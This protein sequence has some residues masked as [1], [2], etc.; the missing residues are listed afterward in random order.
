[1]NQ[2]IYN[3]TGTV[4]NQPIHFPWYAYTIIIVLIYFA[5]KDIIRT[6]RGIKK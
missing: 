6:A 4:S 5:V 3:I 2:T 1:M